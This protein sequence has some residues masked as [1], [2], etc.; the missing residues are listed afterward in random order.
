[1]LTGYLAVLPETGAM[2]GYIYS[3][4]FTSGDAWFFTPLYDAETGEPLALLDGASM[5]PFK[6]GAAGAT[7]VD[8]LA[9]EDARTL[10]LLGSGP[11]A[12]GQLQA[13]LTVREFETVKVYSPTAEHRRSFAEEFN[14]KLAPEVRA[15]SSS[16][17]AVANA[18]V[19]VTA[20][21]SSTPVVDSQDLEDGT[22][23]T[24]MGQ[25]DPGNRELDPETI[26]RAKY[27]PDLRDRAH[28][29]AGAFLHAKE[30]GVIDDDHIHAELGEVV[31]GKKPGRT[32]PGD[33][34][35]FDSGGTG[36]E[37]VAGAYLLYERA[38]QRNRGKPITLASAEEALTG[39]LT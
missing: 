10:G 5:N 35:V 36:V 16:S 4:G 20:T 2:G 31:A 9:R 26:A 12:A 33:L 29:D 18:D 17:D 23:V 13:T 25:Y 22:H 32:S 28:Q 3:G 8:E 21:T 27:V 38:K 11:Q 30:Q 6:T 34:T 14:E 19:V 24:A 15:V 1:M 39:R 7:A 37:T